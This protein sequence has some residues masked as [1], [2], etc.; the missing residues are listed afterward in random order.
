MDTKWNDVMQLIGKIIEKQGDEG[1]SESAMNTFHDKLVLQQKEIDTLIKRVHIQDAHRA[2][3]EH[4]LLNA[5]FGS[6][7][8]NSTTTFKIDNIVNHTVNNPVNG[9]EKG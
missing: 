1:L 6:D 4:K 2:L 3:N 5:R 9:V 8:N 7:P